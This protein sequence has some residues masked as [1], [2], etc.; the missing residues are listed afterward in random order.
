MAAHRR[1]FICRSVF[2]W[3]LNQGQAGQRD[4]P[5]AAAVAAGVEGDSALTCSE[6]LI[7]W[8]QTPRTPFSRSN[9]TADST[10]CREKKKKKKKKH[11]QEF[12]FQGLS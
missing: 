5:Q 10:G 1:A 6:S 9:L 12:M 4:R 7:D 2:R 8:L 3:R 11:K